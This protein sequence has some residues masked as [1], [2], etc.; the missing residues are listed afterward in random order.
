MRGATGSGW[1]ADMTEPH[2]REGT[3]DMRVTIDWVPVAERLPHDGAGIVAAVTGVHPGEDREPFWI[4]LP[5]YFRHVH[6]VEE[7]GEIIMD[8]FYDAD[9]IVRLP[10][11]GPTAEVVTHWA[12]MPVLPGTAVRHMTGDDVGAALRAVGIDQGS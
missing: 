3:D 4:V 10:Y 5:M 12:E 11:G 6:P 9:G 7:T 2:R 8:C 1:V